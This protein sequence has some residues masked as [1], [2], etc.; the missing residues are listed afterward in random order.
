MKKTW[1]EVCNLASVLESCDRLNFTL[2][3]TFDLKGK[4]AAHVK[5]YNKT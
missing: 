5:I 3:S 2:L 4:L 1:K